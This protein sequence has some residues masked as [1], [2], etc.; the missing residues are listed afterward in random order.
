MLNTL[1]NAQEIVNKK[2][3]SAAAQ[4]VFYGLYYALVIMFY[5]L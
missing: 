1:K 5:T 3:K 2:H 4:I